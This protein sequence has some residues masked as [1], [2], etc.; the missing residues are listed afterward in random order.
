MKKVV[1]VSL[2]T[3]DGEISV[4]ASSLEEFYEKTK[5]VDDM[6]AFMMECMFV[7]AIEED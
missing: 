5:H 6:Y 2:T 1:K 4:E 7:R 3:E